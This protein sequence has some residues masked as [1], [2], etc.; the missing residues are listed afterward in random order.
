MV[1]AL[2]VAFGLLLA[3]NARWNPDWYTAIDTE[4]PR[5]TIFGRGPVRAF[6]L[7]GGLVIACVGLAI[8]LGI[9]W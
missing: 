1:G 7:V 2:L 5:V 6:D 9:G 3:G 4:D 8:A